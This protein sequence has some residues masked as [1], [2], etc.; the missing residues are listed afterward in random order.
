MCWKEFEGDW[1]DPTSQKP[2]VLYPLVVVVPVYN[3]IRLTFI[4]VQQWLE[5]FDAFMRSVWTLP[6][7]SEWNIYLTTTNEYKASLITPAKIAT[8]DPTKVFMRHPRFIWRATLL[9]S[10]KETI[11]ILADATGVKEAVPFYHVEVSDPALETTPRSS[12]AGATPDTIFSQMLTDPFV[13]FL[14]THL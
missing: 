5:R 3:K 8:L 1:I 4:N 7:D 13:H 12:L 11:E 6:P 14:S 9:V 2:A 10:G